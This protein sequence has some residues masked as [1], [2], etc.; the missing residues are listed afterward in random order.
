MQSFHHLT[1]SRPTLELHNLLDPA[2][3]AAAVERRFQPDADHALDQLF[4]EEVGREAEDVGVVV[5][6]AQLS[7]D[8]VV[9]GRGPGAPDLVRGDAHADARAANQDTPFHP[10]LADSLGHL[11]GKVRVVRAPRAVRSDVDYLMADLT[12]KRNDPLLDAEA[13]MVTTN[14]NVH[15]AT[16]VSAEC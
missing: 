14:R 15:G 11:E 9:A 16:L 2:G 3:M 12:Q 8:A 13:T 7:R 1:T 4:A 5:T 6:S 10:T